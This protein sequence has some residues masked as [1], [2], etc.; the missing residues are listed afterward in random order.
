M[1][2][3]RRHVV[4]RGVDNRPLHVDCE[5]CAFHVIGV[6]RLFAEVLARLHHVRHRHEVWIGT[7]RASLTATA[8]VF[9]AS[10]G[11]AALIGSLL[12]FSVPPWM[13]IGPVALLP[14]GA[15]LWASIVVLGVVGLAE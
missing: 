4:S 13:N 15:M 12:V 9:S 3:D 7:R 10:V 11:V 8:S 2:S 14:I 5:D 6:N 1:P